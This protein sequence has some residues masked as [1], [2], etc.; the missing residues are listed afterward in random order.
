MLQLLLTEFANQ[1]SQL[2]EYRGIPNLEHLLHEARSQ[3]RQ[4]VVQDN[5]KEADKSALDILSCRLAPT[6]PVG[7]AAPARCDIFET[8]GLQE[9]I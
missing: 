8:W 9:M 5:P 6:P 1:V 4:V 7:T 2:D 3:V